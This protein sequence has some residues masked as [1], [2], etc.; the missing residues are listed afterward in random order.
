MELDQKIEW[1]E[2]ISRELHS[3]GR[4][5]FRTWLEYYQRNNLDSALEYA[6]KLSQ[7]KMLRPQQK[8]AFGSV[9]YGIRKY[10]KDLGS[11]S[12][13]IV[14]DIFG[15]VLWGLHIYKKSRGSR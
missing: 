12:M 3:V 2:S 7:S 5:E 15:Y 14:S 1:A 8:R 11:M 9:F 10:E 13:E 4:N 6:R